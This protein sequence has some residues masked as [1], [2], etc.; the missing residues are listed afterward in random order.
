MH[1]VAVQSYIVTSSFR[2]LFFVLGYSSPGCFLALV[3]FALEICLNWSNRDNRLLLQGGFLQSRFFLCKEHKLRNP[4]GEDLISSF[5]RRLHTSPTWAQH[6]WCI[7]DIFLSTHIFYQDC[8]HK[9]QISC[10]HFF[11]ST[12]VV[13]S[14]EFWH[15]WKYRL[16]SYAGA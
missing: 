15:L 6:F 1:K 7:T 4:V 8:F 12:I 13:E 3:K 11:K 2:I 9:I 10:Q 16:P 14:S 5:R